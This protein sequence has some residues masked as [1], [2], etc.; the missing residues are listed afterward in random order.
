[1]GCATAWQLGLKGQKV[2]LLEQDAV[3]HTKAASQDASKAFRLEYA[4][5]ELYTHA[6]I[7]AQQEWSAFE[8][9]ANEEL[10]YRCG[11]L[12]L[13][14]SEES[15]AVKSHRVLKALGQ[16]SDWL[17]R[18]ALSTR[19]P[20]FSAE[21]ASFSPS[22][23][24]LDAGRT[25]MALARLAKAGGAVIRENSK[26]IALESDYLRLAGGERIDFDT[27]VITTGA[28]T[29]QLGGWPVQP[30]RQGLLYFKP[31]EPA[32]YQKSVFPVFA[33]LDLGWYGFPIHGPDQTLKIS[34]HL[35]GEP[36][37]VDAHRKVADDF[38]AAGRAFFEASIPGLV[39]AELVTSGVCLYSMTSNED[40]IIQ[41]V[42][43][44]V[45]GAGFSGHGFKF[46]PLIGR[47]LACLALGEDPGFDLSRFRQIV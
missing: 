30:T 43:R 35:V 37:T 2:L 44:H 10:F 13:D 20:A 47:W 3:G 14:Q 31:K 8:S 6:A 42:G 45:I 22:G 40:F 28:W 27:A 17:E 39:D 7:L 5:D 19:F 26:V 16:E 46:A 1:M 41:R 21:K 12:M 18:A 29:N 23:G 9:A 34:C 36:W 24:L 11:I 38:E 32:L 25:T 4:D 15:Y 33:D